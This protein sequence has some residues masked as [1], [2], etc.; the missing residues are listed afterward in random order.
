M[1]NFN[2]SMQANT[3]CALIIMMKTHI[4]ACIFEQM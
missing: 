1:L 2:V 4:S 3:L